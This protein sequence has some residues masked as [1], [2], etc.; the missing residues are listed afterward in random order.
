MGT[1]GESIYGKTY[2]FPGKMIH[3]WHVFHLYGALPKGVK[4]VFYST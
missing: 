3:K 2:A 4:I 1:E